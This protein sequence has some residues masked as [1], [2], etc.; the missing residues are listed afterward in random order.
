MELTDAYKDRIVDFKY[1]GDVVKTEDGSKVTTP[2]IV[3]LA[4]DDATLPTLIFYVGKCIELGT[5]QQHIQGLLALIERVKK[6]REENPN[7]C[8]VPD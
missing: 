6:W 8:K 3:L 1:S 4:K 2:W 5:S 7:L